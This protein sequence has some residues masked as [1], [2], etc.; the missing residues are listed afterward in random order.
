MCNVYYRT[1][2]TSILLL[3][4]IAVPGIYFCLALDQ[5]G[6]MTTQGTWFQAC[7]GISLMSGHSVWLIG[8]LPETLPLLLPSLSLSI[9]ALF[10]EVCVLIGRGNVS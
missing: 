8:L 10:S 4:V 1:Y 5:P 6:R 9:I 2:T 3:I 7:E